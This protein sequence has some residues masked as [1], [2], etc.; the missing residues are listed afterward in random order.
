MARD[1][2]EL[3]KQALPRGPAW[4]RDLSSVAHKLYT[5]LMAEMV[6][7]DGR[8]L[9]LL[10]E[11]CPAETTELI[12]DWERVCGLPDDCGEPPYTL[13]DRRAAVVSKIISRGGW[14]GGPSVPFLT[15]LIVALGYSSANIEIRRFKFPEFTCNSNC[16]APLNSGGGWPYVWEVVVV[17][18]TMDD[19]VQ[20]RVQD[21]ALAHLGLM[22]SFPLMRFET[23]TITRAGAAVFT[24]PVNGNQYAVGANEIGTAYT[25]DNSQEYVS[26]P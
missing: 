2:V 21:Y 6:R 4:T 12:A 20:C 11:M 22:F 19:V 18:G 5:G 26:Y 16:D 7:V 1:Y 3:F 24:D 10:A 25:F 17:S 23:A 9:Q 13:A 15:S 14:S 8:A